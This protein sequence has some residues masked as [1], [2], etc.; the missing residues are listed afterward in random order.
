M[1]KRHPLD[2][3]VALHDIVGGE[4]RTLKAVQVAGDLGVRI[5]L[6]RE[7]AGEK[8]LGVGQ[9]LFGGA[10]LPK[11][12]HLGLCDV[13]R[14][15]N[16]A[17]LA[18]HVADNDAGAAEIIERHGDSVGET[19][20][21]AD[22]IHQSG[23]ESA[24]AEDVIR[25]KR[26][27]EVG[28]GAH[29][30]RKAEDGH[31]RGLIQGNRL[32]ARLRHFGGLW[33]ERHGFRRKR[34]ENLLQIFLHLRGR[35]IARNRDLH[36]IAD[37]MIG[38]KA[39]DVGGGDRIDAGRR[40]RDRMRVGMRAEIRRIPG[41][42]RNA[43]WLFFFLL[44]DRIGI[45]AGMLEREG[46]KAETLI[47][48]LFEHRDGDDE[49][50][51]FRGCGHPD[52]AGFERLFE[53]IRG[54]I[55]RAFIEERGGHSGQSG[56]CRRIVSR[57]RGKRDVHRDHGKGMLFRQPCLDALRPIYRLDRDRLGCGGN[58]KQNDKRKERAHAHGPLLA[59][60]RAVTDWSLRR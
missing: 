46:K 49:E 31:R 28:I 26:R 44:H 22:L 43:G 10:V 53:G 37:E 30:T 57:A 56:L 39:L 11:A 27:N 36:A 4:P 24:A 7:R 58:E 20:P 47:R 34:C 54:E 35:Q 42:G 12:R 1:R 29:G 17:L 48:I 18:L 21:V 38:D 14:G 33:R 2:H 25:H 16:L 6:E 32:R 51:A 45:E 13:E 3:G 55:A 9:F 50:V 52:R 5:E 41:F 40:S 59:E 23:R 15:R 8:G 60:S 19:A